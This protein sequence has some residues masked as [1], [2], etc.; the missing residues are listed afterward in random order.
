MPY[1][2]NITRYRSQPND[3]NLWITAA[4]LGVLLL[5][6]TVCIFLDIT[7]SGFSTANIALG[8]AIVWIIWELSNRK[9]K[10]TLVKING[11]S[12]EYFSTDAEEMITIPAEEIVKVSTRFCELRIHTEYDVHSINMSMIPKEQTRWE[13]KEMIRIV[14]RGEHS[15]L[16]LAV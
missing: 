8:A 1:Q 11:D 15:S 10:I 14:A 13:I 5:L 7:S 12:I 9:Q 3:K 16:S 4:V 6:N 2:L